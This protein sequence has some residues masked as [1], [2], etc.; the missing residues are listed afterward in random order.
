[1]T[2]ETAPQNADFSTQ[3]LRS[4]NDLTGNEHAK[5]SALAIIR[6]PGTPPKMFLAGPSASGKSTTIDHACRV[7][8]CYNSQGDEPCGVCPGC[9]KF[10]ATHRD[11]GLLAYFRD[12][13]NPR[14]LHYLPINCRNTTP[15][16]IHDE[17]F[18]IKH[19][20][21]QRII[22][23]EEVAN[24]KRLECDESITD[25]MDDPNYRTCRW[26]ASA[27]N[28]HGLDLQFR[29]RWTLK[30]RTSPPSEHDLACFLAR[31]CTEYGIGIDHPGTWQLL[32]KLSWQI[33]GLATAVLAN[34]LMEDPPRL[35]AEMVREY[36]LPLSNPWDEESFAR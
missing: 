8:A 27:V 23:L 14:P 3:H 1:M 25:I 17:L 32:A 30:V 28:D 24:L 21:G 15:T 22:H 2:S 26:F 5:K 29:R 19:V 11:T 18:D 4:W 9:K 10:T 13:D 12:P 20:I 36:P 33:V 16:Q 7:A 34:A 35:T 6:H 31:R